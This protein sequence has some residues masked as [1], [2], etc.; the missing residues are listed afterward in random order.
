MT[1]Q[2]IEHLNWKEKM[3]QEAVD[4]E[5]FRL[6]NI[7]KKQ[8]IKI[9]NLRKSLY[10]QAFFFISLFSIL[11][12]KGMISFSDKK[13]TKEFDAINNKYNKLV[14]LQHSLNDSL[15]QYKNK[16]NSV[17]DKNRIE[18]DENGLRFRVQIGAFKEI[19]LN[20]YK[21]NLV[22][23]NQESYDSINQYTL[24]IFRNYEKALV[25]WEDIKKMGFNDSFIISTK[26]G[27]RIPLEKLR[28]E[29][30]LFNTTTS[31]SA[32]KPLHQETGDSLQ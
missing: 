27:R 16:F 10:F 7:N 17:L 11:L 12:L 25:F 19:D 26:N 9:T 15:T 22:A 2:E 18:R 3:R 24:G 21:N 28:K 32:V 30:N 1:P 23:I 5:V 13:S 14:L 6:R 20:N 4:K 29:I 8:S 31:H